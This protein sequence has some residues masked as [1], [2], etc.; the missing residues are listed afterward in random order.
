MYRL[1]QRA[2]HRSLVCANEADRCTD[3]EDARGE[4]SHGSNG[5]YSKKRGGTLHGNSSMLAFLCEAAKVQQLPDGLASKESN[6]SLTRSRKQFNTSV[7]GAAFAR[8]G[9]ITRQFHPEKLVAAHVYGY[10]SYRSPTR[11]W[12]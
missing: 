5:E 7:V 3:D 9:A 10:R 1:N 8:S 11:H 12:C 4:R 2:S 6:K